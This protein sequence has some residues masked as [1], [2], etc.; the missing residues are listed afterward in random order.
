MSRHVPPPTS[1]ADRWLHLATGRRTAWVVALIPLLL[2]AAIIG[3]LGEGER[4]RL[5]TDQ[6]PRRVR[7]HPGGRAP[8]SACRTPTARSPSS[9]SRPEP[10]T[11]ASRSPSSSSASSAPSWAS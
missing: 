8:P 4:D 3:G 5:P 9:S 6:L 10:P 7:L 11:T 1:L 2:G